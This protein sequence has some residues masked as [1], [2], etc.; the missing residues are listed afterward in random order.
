VNLD[1]S[2]Y[3]SGRGHKHAAMDLVVKDKLALRPGLSEGRK[4]TTSTV[5]RLALGQLALRMC[6]M[7]LTP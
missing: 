2:P 4:N 7:D 3:T 6:R 5:M 1:K